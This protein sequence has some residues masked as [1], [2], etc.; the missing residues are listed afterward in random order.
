MNTFQ[1]TSLFLL[2]LALGW[3]YLYAGGSALLNPA[4][5]AAGYLKSAQTF[6]G[7]YLWL[8]N[9]T[10]IG[11]VNFVNKWAL[12]LLGTSLILGLF[13]RLAGYAG[14]LLML[15]FCFVILHF[16]YAGQGTISFIVD[17]HVIFALV[18]IYFA[19]IDAGRFWGL[20]TWCAHLA[21]CKKHPKLRALFG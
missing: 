18:L 13:V 15:L 8:A 9:P 7:F 17:P 5:S 3:M 20:D 1:K 12:L 19:A 4:W 11:W 16:P 6:E 2:R 10:N 21:W 14:A